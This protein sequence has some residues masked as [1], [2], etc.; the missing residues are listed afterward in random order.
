MARTRI[1]LTSQQLQEIYAFRRWPKSAT[2]VWNQPRPVDPV[3]LGT[4]PAPIDNDALADC[5]LLLTIIARTKPER[6]AEFFSLTG[7]R[8][9]KMAFLLRYGSFEQGR[10]KQ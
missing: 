8:H 4:A 5:C 7:D 9:E 1:K 6:V 3:V 2:G 10:W